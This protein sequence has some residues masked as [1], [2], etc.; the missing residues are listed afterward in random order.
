M[1]KIKSGFFLLPVVLILLNSCIG[2][3]LDIQMNR[4]GSGR[5]TMEYRISDM[6][7]GIGSLDGNESMPVIPVSRSDWERSIEGLSGVKLVSYSSRETAHNAAQQNVINAVFD[8][9]NP[10]SLAALL[11]KTGETVTVSQNSIGMILLNEPDARYDEN[12]ISLMR[13]FYNG[14]NFSLNFSAQG[15][16]ALMTTDG[17]GNNRAAP[18]GASVVTSGRKVSLSMG[19]MDILELPGGL[20][21]RINW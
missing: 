16:C 4:D 21:V 7:S 18:S 14:Y 1:L 6:I 15:N 5:L 19:V 9:S 20:G 10:E 13:S 2:I 11:D 8:F 17:R 12:L 3:S